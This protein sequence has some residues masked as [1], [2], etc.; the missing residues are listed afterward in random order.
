MKAASEDMGITEK[1]F[2]YHFDDF[3]LDLEKVIRE[4]STCDDCLAGRVCEE[5]KLTK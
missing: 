2:N 1:Q 4:M 3:E 5:H